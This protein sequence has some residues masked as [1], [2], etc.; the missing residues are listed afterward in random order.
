LANEEELMHPQWILWGHGLLKG[1]QYGAG[2]AREHALEKHQLR[3]PISELL[4][5]VRGE[6]LVARSF[7]LGSIRLTRRFFESNKLKS[8]S[9]EAC[10]DHVRAILTSFARTVNK[11]GFEVAVGSSGTIGAVC[12]M[13]LAKRGDP[14][15]QTLNFF[16]LTRKDVNS[17]VKSLI[18]ASTPAAR[19]KLTGL[20]AKRADIILAGALILEAVFEEF[21]LKSMRFSEYALREG[22]LLDAWRRRHGGSLHHLSDL[23]KRSVEHLAHLMDEDPDHSAEVSR[24]ALNLFDQTADVHGLG[25]DAR[26]YLEAAALLCNVGLFLS[27]AGHHKH[28]YYVIRN[29]EHLTGFTDREIEL[30][31]QIARYHRKGVPAS[32]HPE[33]SSLS[34]DDQYL[35]RCC[36]GLLRIAIGLDRTHGGRVEGVEVRMRDKTLEVIAVARD[37]VDLELE[38]FSAAQRVDLAAEA[39]G[40]PVEVVQAVRV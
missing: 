10:R 36:A 18:K 19:A 11:Q 15:L 23:R 8:G 6:S 12:S 34:K 2:V 16:E 40:L 17:V 38:V 25:D 14:A 7:K 26:E 30:M 29:S 5:G 21:E 24:L 33:F 3:K 4:L 1:F 32:K 22:V 27:H 28:S 37:G 9:V 20:D 31:A 35:V 39:L 13:A